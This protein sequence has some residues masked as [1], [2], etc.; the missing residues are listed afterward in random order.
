MISLEKL[1]IE[2]FRGFAARLEINLASDAILVT[3]PD[4]LGKTSLTDAITWALTGTLPQMPERK[5]RRDE[6]FVVN[7]YRPGAEAEVALSV[8]HAGVVTRVR[9]VGS[10]K[11]GSTLSLERDGRVYS[12]EHADHELWGIFGVTSQRELDLA[13][14]GWGILRQDAM[15]AVLTAPAEEF[16]ARLRD[17]LGLGVL[18]EFEAAARAESKRAA[19]EEAAAR[20]EVD[21]LQRALSQAEAQIHSVSRSVADAEPVTLAHERLETW[22]RT[23]AGRV[24]F[25]VPPAAQVEAARQLATQAGDAERRLRELRVRQSE[26][27]ALRQDDATSELAAAREALRQAERELDEGRSEVQRAEALQAE[28]AARSA[29]L[30]QLAASA[31]PLLTETCPVCENPI[32]PEAVAARLQ[33]IVAGEESGPELS[34]AG[35]AAAAS[36]SRLARIEAAFGASHHAVALLEQRTAQAREAATE[37]AEVESKILALANAP[38]LRLPLLGRGSDRSDFDFATTVEALVELQ[39]AVTSV[40]R[41]ASAVQVSSRLPRLEQELANV[42]ERQRLATDKLEA[43]A[44]HASTA[45]QLSVAATSAAL[46]VTEEALTTIGPYFGEVFRRLAA[47]PTFSELGLEHDVYYGKARTWARLRDPVSDVNVNPQLIL[48]EGQLNVVALSY[49]VA[50]ALTAGDK[51]LPFLV[52]DDPLQSLDDMNVLGF[53]DLCRHLRDGRQLVIT[54][55][56]P[57]FG[58]LLE[59]KLRPRRPDQTLTRIHFKSWDRDGPEFSVDTFGPQVPPTLLHRDNGANGSAAEVPDA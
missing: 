27:N 57:R 45:Q 38:D 28:V 49:F 4:G 29:E 21:E 42:R 34:L 13:A 59:R 37:L 5:A 7:R 6:E 41:A 36:R 31:L 32:R 43:L 58:R 23:A 9:R 3:G 8:R 50:F 54:T 24:E 40:L 35:E 46:D 53:G 14:T 19:D 25:A 52:L 26:L 22:A 17:I 56:D 55:H 47:H 15:R 30:T 10:S 16:Q 51:A 33:R 39:R 18:A 20:S 48:S 2:A 44:R 11:T 12:G 1:E